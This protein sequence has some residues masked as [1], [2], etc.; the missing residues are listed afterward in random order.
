MIVSNKCHSA[1]FF[2][3]KAEQI[4]LWHCL[5]IFSVLSSSKA[6]ITL[7]LFVHDQSNSF[8][9]SFFTGFSLV[10]VFG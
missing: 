4:F 2:F 3:L 7:H 1:P 8:I 5:N 9:V 6:V 10:W